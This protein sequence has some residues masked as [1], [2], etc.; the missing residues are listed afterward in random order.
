MK[1]IVSEYLVAAAVAIGAAGA[2]IG[3]AET[4]VGAAAVLFEDP[5]DGR[6]VPGWIVPPTPFAQTPAGD[7]AFLLTSEVPGL[8]TPS[9]WVGDET[10]RNYRLTV[11]IMPAREQ[12]FL[13]VDFNV[14]RGDRCGGN[15]HF[16]TGRERVRLQ[17]MRNC[18]PGTESWKLWP[19]SQR[20]IAFPKGQWIR[21]R[22]DAGE[23]VAN[24]YVNDDPDPTCTIF[25]LPSTAGGIRFWA[26]WGGSG[27]YRNLR[28][29]QLAPQDVK[30]LLTDIWAEA[31]RQNVVHDWRVTGLQPA[32]FGGDG[33]PAE[34]RSGKLEW[35]P[36]KAD[37]RGV[38]DLSAAFRHYD[39]NTVYAETVVKSDEEVVR[40]AWVTYTDRLTLYCN[41]EEVFKGPDRHWFSPEREKYGNSRLIPDQFEVR[42][43]LKAG[44]NRLIVRSEALEQFGWG[45][46]MRLDQ[47]GTAPHGEERKTSTDSTPEQLGVSA[48]TLDKMNAMI[49]QHVD[50]GELAGAV[51]LFARHGKVVQ[52]KAYGSMDIE[53][54]KP[55][56]TDAIFRIASMNKLPTCVA[57]LKLYEEGRFSLDDPIAKFI[58]EMKNLRVLDSSQLAAPGGAPPKTVPLD[59]Q[60]TIRDLFRHTAG[61]LYAIGDSPVDQLYRDAGFR[62]WKGSLKDFVR[63]LSDFPLAYQPGS[64]WAYSYSTDVLGYLIEVISHQPL[65]EYL[66]THVF[67]PLRMGDTDYVVPDSKVDW[68]TSFY[69]YKDRSLHL[70]ESTTESPFRRLPAGFSGGGGWGD[71]YGG[72]VSTATDLERFLQMLLNYGE[73]DGVRI[74][75]RE[76]VELMIAD[77]IADI[78]DRSFPVSGYGLGLGVY[79]DP[80]RPRQTQGIFWSGGPYN[81]HFIADFDLQMCGVL[82]TQ[83]APFGHLGIIGR[84]SEQFGELAAAAALPSKQ[85][86]PGVPETKLPATNDAN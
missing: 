34:I 17:P 72:V 6:S 70:V 85:P 57:A 24:V 4:N 64:K 38:V 26:S 61:F 82:L 62:E 25:D 31:S 5:L 58:P 13:G 3:F 71:G 63:K 76:T 32:G 29:T 14:R 28:V 16:A 73:L 36:I 74:L 22:I 40:S 41:G 15:V 11:E 9:P 39:R 77:Q 80:A 53:S 86:S 23:T 20:E 37:R 42:L 2:D 21:L 55:M 60:I 44:E 7:T 18:G 12:G 43:S 33:L 68:L 56:R 51:T 66:K 48:A 75:R 45:F 65:N 84:F 1:K 50:R 49:Q 59:R 52:L 35:K 79:S 81:T 54:H 8:V 69:E 47:Q 46:W 27:Y 19:V 67:E 78:R 10:W 83:T 30:P